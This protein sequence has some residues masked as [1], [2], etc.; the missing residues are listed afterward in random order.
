M[1]AIRVDRIP[2]RNS[3]L[4]IAAKNDQGSGSP[5]GIFILVGGDRE[6]VVAF[7]DGIGHGILPRNNSQ[8]LFLID[9][10]AHLFASCAGRGET[11]AGRM[12]D[13]PFHVD[14]HRS[15]SRSVPI[16][17]SKLEP[18]EGMHAGS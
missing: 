3:K 14:P 12:K 9:A 7:Q 1:R 4:V 11:T 17:H 5:I 15:D 13:Q 2:S 6:L 10:F 8:C 18:K 16:G